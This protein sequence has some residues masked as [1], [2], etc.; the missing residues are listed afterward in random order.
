MEVNEKKSVGRFAKLA[1]GARNLGLFLLGLSIFFGVVAVFF[2]LICHGVASGDLKVS[3]GVFIATMGT[4]MLQL[5]LLGF[6][7]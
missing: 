4:T 3:E 6:G 1:K 7:A 5:L 2:W